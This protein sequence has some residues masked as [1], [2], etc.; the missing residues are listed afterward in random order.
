MAVDIK[1][2]E[3]KMDAGIGCPE[4]RELVRTDVE[5]LPLSLLDGIKVN[6]YGSQMAI[7]QVGSLTIPENNMIA[8]A[9][10]TG[11]VSH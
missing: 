2:I 6:A 11:A 4:A 5:G 1:E 10:S 3:G 7:D 9:G 8:I